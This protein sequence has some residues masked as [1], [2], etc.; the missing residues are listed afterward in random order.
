V[1]EK[2]EYIINLDSA[3]N[4]LT[5]QNYYKLHLPHDLP[6]CS[7]W[8]LIVYDSLTHLMIKTAQPWPSVYKS[9]K[10]LLVNQDG[11]LDVWFGPIAPGGRENNWI[12]TIPRKG[13]YIILRLYEPQADC[14]DGTWRPREIELV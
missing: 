4:T 13:W 10:K 3:G 11:S 6:E 14:L 2:A 8:S 12:R 9:C 5:G 1:N 7:F